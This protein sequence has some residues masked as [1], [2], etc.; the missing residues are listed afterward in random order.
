MKIAV[1]VD[2][3]L[4]DFITPFLEFY[5]VRH[6][7][8]WKREQIH[9]YN[10]WEQFGI[11]KQQA[12][13]EVREFYKSQEFRNLSLVRYAFDVCND[14]SKDHELYA[15]T[16]R[17]A[18]ISGETIEQVET[19]FPGVFRGIHL[20]NQWGDEGAKRTKGEV[21]IELGAA[22]L[23]DDSYD[24]LFEAREKGINGLLLHSPW[25]VGFSSKGIQ[26]VYSWEDVPREVIFS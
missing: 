11:E 15:V 7:A 10:L 21:C 5:N 23:V 16:S 17:P 1:D 6:G 24:Y 3:V 25:N 2:E 8:T 20:T 9:T 4:F 14:L 22:A 12:V 13:D 19:G 26:R 18:F